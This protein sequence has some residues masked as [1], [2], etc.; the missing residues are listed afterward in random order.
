MTSGDWRKYIDLA[1]REGLA[2]SDQVDP[3]HT[4]PRFTLSRNWKNEM[5]VWLRLPR[6]MS[7]LIIRWWMRKQ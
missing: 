1:R 7:A 4:E 3:D 2:I 6:W 5:G